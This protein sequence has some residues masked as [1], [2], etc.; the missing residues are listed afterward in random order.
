MG[1]PKCLRP[2]WRTTELISF[3]DCCL[4][5][6]VPEG[7]CQQKLRFSQLWRDEN[8]RARNGKTCSI[9]S[10]QSYLGWR[11]ETFFYCSIQL[12]IVIPTDFHIFQRGR[13]TT[14]HLSY[15]TIQRFLLGC[16]DSHGCEESINANHVVCQLKV[17]GAHRIHQH[18]ISRGV[19][20]LGAPEHCNR[21]GM[22]QKRRFILCTWL[23]V[24]NHGILWLSVDW[25]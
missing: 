7:F 9:F 2:A 19:P 1:L 22:G 5:L 23:V 14:T 15:P 20:I 10:M 16:R 24:W 11:F 4:L 6:P 17:E 3:G 25:E 12:G 13:Y 21:M 18:R 8:Q